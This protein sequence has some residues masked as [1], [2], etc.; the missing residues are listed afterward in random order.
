[1]FRS[2]R[3][4]RDVA[5]AKTPIWQACLATSAAP[6]IF[7][8]T[9]IGETSSRYFDGGIG[10]NNPIDLVVREKG[11]LWP[12]RD[13]GCIVSIGT[14]IPRSSEWGKCLSKNIRAC[15]AQTTESEATARRF[16]DAIKEKYGPDQKVYYRFNV[17]KDLG[18]IELDEWKQFDTIYNSTRDYLD[19]ERSQLNTCASQILSPISR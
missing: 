1:M 2:Y 12:S 15:K 16:Y 6:G 17:R 7:G 18:N 14:G 8:P 9:T 3:S 4:T 5:I 13:I 11:D 10:N 19:E